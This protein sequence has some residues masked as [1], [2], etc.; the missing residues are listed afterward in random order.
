MRAKD[1]VGRYGEQLAVDHLERLGL[2]VLERNWRCDAG[3]LDVVAVDGGCLVVVEV[4]TRRSL[5]YGHP[6]DAVT[7]VKLARLRRLAARWLH[8]STR[9]FDHVR[10]DVVAVLWPRTGIS[11][12]QHLRGVG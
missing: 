3:E 11:Q 8:E 9:S 6:A 10:I 2:E 5:D 7:A 12:L 1:V 4:K